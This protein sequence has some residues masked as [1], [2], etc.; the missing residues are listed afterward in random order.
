MFFIACIIF[1]NSPLPL[2][3]MLKLLGGFFFGFYPGAL[4]NIAATIIACLV[5]F[6]LSRY[7]FKETFEKRYYER[8]KNIEDELETN[9][10]YYL[11]TLRLIM[12]IP[13][14]LI[15]ILAG[16]SRISFKTYFFSTVIGVTPASLV[17]A[18]AGSKL[19]EIDSV[20]Q[21]LSPTTFIAFIL[22]ALI[23]LFPVLNKKFNI[24]TRSDF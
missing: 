14:A 8:L 15:N 12:L 19:E 1:V 17:Y 6:G 11:L 3:A 20:S 10:F 18:N 13:Y 5:G 21:L 24:I 16:I 23:V 4:F 2:A 9:G 22:V 7:T